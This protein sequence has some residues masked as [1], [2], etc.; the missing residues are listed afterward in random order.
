MSNESPG[1]SSPPR[2]RNL[3]LAK[4]LDYRLNYRSRRL[5]DS[6]EPM[7]AKPENDIGARL[8][9]EI[10]GRLSSRTGRRGFTVLDTSPMSF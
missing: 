1:T 3:I 5:P 9:S 7:S 2:R 10:A 8:R 6:G 4:E